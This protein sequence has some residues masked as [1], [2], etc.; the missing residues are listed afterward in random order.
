MVVCGFAACVRV[1]E[2][3]LVVIVLVAVGVSI[4]V[5]VASVVVVVVVVGVVAVDSCNLEVLGPKTQ[6]V[7]M[8]MA[9]PKK[10]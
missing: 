1:R 4:I 10:Q 9:S 5:L 6:M 7:A 2:V 3:A 8:M